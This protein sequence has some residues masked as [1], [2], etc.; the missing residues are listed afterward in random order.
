MIA[1]SAQVG[2]NQCAGRK[3]RWPRPSLVSRRASAARAMRVHSQAAIVATSLVTVGC[4]VNRESTVMWNDSPAGA[5]P[6]RSENTPT[7]CGRRS[8]GWVP[9]TGTVFVVPS[10]C[11]TCVVRL[12]KVAWVWS[13]SETIEIVSQCRSSERFADATMAL[14]LTTS[15]VSGVTRTNI[16]CSAAR[17]PWGGAVLSTIA[18]VGSFATAAHGIFACRS[19]GICGHQ[20]RLDIAEHAALRPVHLRGGLIHRQERGGQGE[21]R[22]QQARYQR[23]RSGG[24]KIARRRRFSGGRR[25]CQD[26]CCGVGHGW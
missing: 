5:A 8:P 23:D 22:T 12:P 3:R 1:A 15:T 18:P 6:F 9:W 19:T 25:S 21:Q 16:A 13:I 24:A 7:T 2:F 26:S 14:R 11:W 20:R 17:S 4:E 10:G